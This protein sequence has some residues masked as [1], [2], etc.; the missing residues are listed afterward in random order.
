MCF[1]VV[2]S[3]KQTPPENFLNTLAPLPNPTHTT[4]APAVTCKRI[5]GL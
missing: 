5:K 2:S 1:Y 4:C 3:K